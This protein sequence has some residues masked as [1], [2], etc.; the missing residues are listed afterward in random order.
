MSRQI[1]IYSGADKN[2]AFLI[3]GFEEYLGGKKKYEKTYSNFVV[4]F[5]C[6]LLDISMGL[7]NLNYKYSHLI[8]QPHNDKN[9]TLISFKWS[10]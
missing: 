8:K 2:H 5:G 10:L 1:Q 4:I 6:P 3:V 9:E 7:T